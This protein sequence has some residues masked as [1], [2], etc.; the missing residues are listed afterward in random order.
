MYRYTFFFKLGSQGFSESYYRQSAFSNINNPLLNG[1]I[2]YRLAL[3]ASDTKLISVRASNIDSTRDVQILPVVTG[4]LSGTWNWQDEEDTGPLETAPED[5]FT[6]LM[7]SQHSEGT[8][9]RAFKLLG[10]PDHI[11]IQNRVDPSAQAELNR[12]LLDYE[13]VIRECAFSMRV[14]TSTANT[15]DVLAYVPGPG[16]GSGLVGVQ[17]SGTAPAVGARIGFRR[18][19]NNGWMNRIWVVGSRSTDTVGLAGT[20]SKKAGGAFAG[21]KYFIPTYGFAALTNHTVTGVRSKKSGVP[22]DTVHGRRSK[23]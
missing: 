12:R 6:A 16:A 9:R 8:A 22:F 17:L 5:S 13:R 3:A 23:R 1:Y 11:F 15:G 21:G 4:G 2:G 7:L 10:C 18:C 14:L 20:E 19:K